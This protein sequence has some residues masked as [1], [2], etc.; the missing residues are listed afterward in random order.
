MPADRTLLET[1][2]GLIELA[3]LPG[4]IALMLLAVG[5][6]LAFAPQRAMRTL[7]DGFGFDG[8]A[9]SRSAARRLPARAAGLLLAGYGVFLLG[10]TV[11]LFRALHL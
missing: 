10:N 6:L 7:G 4:I 3:A 5:G 11:G 1:T 9:A 2:V 8:A